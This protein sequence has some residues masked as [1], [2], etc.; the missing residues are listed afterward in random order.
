MNACYQPP[1]HLPI[2]Y[3]FMNF[4]IPIKSVWLSIFSMA[5]W[6][7]E[8]PLSGQQSSE[9]PRSWL[10]CSVIRV[11][12]GSLQCFNRLCLSTRFWLCLHL[13][14]FITPYIVSK[15]TSKLF[16]LISLFMMSKNTTFK[17]Q[18][19]C[20]FF[21]IY[22]CDSDYKIEDILLFYGYHR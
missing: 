18:P 21:F 17:I 10:R 7:W 13:L 20:V 6:T 9:S 4:W 8:G 19:P 2:P 16:I 5:C 3:N 11:C 14:S 15:C 1:L 22:C 12:R